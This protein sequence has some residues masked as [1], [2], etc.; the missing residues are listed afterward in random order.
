MFSLFKT[1]LGGEAVAERLDQLMLKFKPEVQNCAA[2]EYSA[3][4]KSGQINQPEVGGR[5]V[6]ELF[7]FIQENLNL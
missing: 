4:F 5:P 2:G 6:Q 1:G 3:T 7:P